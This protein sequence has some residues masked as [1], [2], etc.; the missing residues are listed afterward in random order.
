M[1]KKLGINYTCSQMGK[2]KG[3]VNGRLKSKL[4]IVREFPICSILL[5]NVTPL[6]KLFN[7]IA[8]FI[9]VNNPN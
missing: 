3:N 2:L 9:N 1:G 5:S 8:H 6:Q 7:N 4:R